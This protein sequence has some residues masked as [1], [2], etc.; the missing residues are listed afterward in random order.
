MKTENIELLEK[1]KINLDDWDNMQIVDMK[2]KAE[3]I[4]SCFICIE[5]TLAP[6]IS[7]KES[8]IIQKTKECLLSYLDKYFINNPLV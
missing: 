2:M 4:I 8:E 1:Y 5:N 3:T 6:H 7:P